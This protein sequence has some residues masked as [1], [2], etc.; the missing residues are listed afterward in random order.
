MWPW[1]VKMRTELAPICFPS[2]ARCLRFPRGSKEELHMMM[3]AFCIS[4][5]TQWIGLTVPN[6]MMTRGSSCTI[7]G[8]EP[9][10]LT[11]QGGANFVD[12]VRIR[13]C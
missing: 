9:E 3:Y 2:A 7:S 13:F 8:E 5:K 12:F 1:L 6:W 11:E 10:N 4:R